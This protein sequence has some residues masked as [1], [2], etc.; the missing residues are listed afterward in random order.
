MLGLS[1]GI[2]CVLITRADCVAT[3]ASLL[4]LG[5]LIASFGTNYFSLQSWKIVG[6][7]RFRAVI[8][9]D[10]LQFAEV[11]PMTLSR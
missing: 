9:G 3:F 2:R 8:T 10:E 6:A 1:T 11:C 7:T 4:S 5:R